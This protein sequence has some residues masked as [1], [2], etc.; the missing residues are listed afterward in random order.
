MATFALFYK[1]Q[2][3]F[4]AMVLLKINGNRGNKKWTFFFTESEQFWIAVEFF[5][6]HF[7]NIS[8]YNDLV[9]HLT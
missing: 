3:N 2:D 8:N 1:L 6:L 9:K 5:L 7:D 4:D